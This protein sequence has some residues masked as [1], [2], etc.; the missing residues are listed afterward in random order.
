MAL[1]SP[2]G[3]AKLEVNLLI[4][5]NF[6]F[7]RCTGSSKVALGSVLPRVLI[8]SRLDMSMI[9]SVSF[10]VFCTPSVAVGVSILTSLSARGGYFQ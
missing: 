8:V 10:S 6:L 1:S 3:V 4:A 9:S 5:S 7:L 2:Y